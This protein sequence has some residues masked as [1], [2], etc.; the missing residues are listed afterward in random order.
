MQKLEQRQ[1]PMPTISIS[2]W[3]TASF[4]LFVVACSLL[5]AVFVVAMMEQFIF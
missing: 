2:H 3:K 5:L 1:A 4:T